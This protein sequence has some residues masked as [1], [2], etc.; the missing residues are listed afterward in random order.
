[1][2]YL[3]KKIIAAFLG[4]PANAYLASKRN[5]HE[6]H[7]GDTKAAKKDSSPNQL[8]FL[9]SGQGERKLFTFSL[10]FLLRLSA[11]LLRPCTPQREDKSTKK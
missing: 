9:Y 5:G 4:L 8:E 2:P 11:L 10:T 6:E 3:P 1:L 7:E